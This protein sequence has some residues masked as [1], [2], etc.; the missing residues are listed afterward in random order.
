M[1]F[2]PAQY[3]RRL[4]GTLEDG[5]GI[6]FALTGFFMLCVVLIMARTWNRM[7]KKVGDIAL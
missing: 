7:L 3:Y 1:L 2:V 6:T 4:E 5:G